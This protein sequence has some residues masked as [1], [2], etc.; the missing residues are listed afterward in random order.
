MN[1][2][3]YILGPLISLLGTISVYLCSFLLAS[4]SKELFGEYSEF[5]FLMNIFVT[6]ASLS[7]D[8]QMVRSQLKGDKDFEPYYFQIGLVINSILSLVYI[9]VLSAIALDDY[10]FSFFII[11]SQFVI[12]FISSIFQIKKLYVYMSI[13]LNLANVLRLIFISFIVFFLDIQDVNY[14]VNGYI[15]IH[16]MV[17]LLS[18]ICFYF[19]FDDVKFNLCRFSINDWSSKRFKGLILLAIAPILHMMIYQS[20]IVLLSHSQPSVVV[21]EYGLALTIITG[22][23]YFPSLIFNKYILPYSLEIGNGGR[24]G[25]KPILSYFIFSAIFTLIV[26]I[27]SDFMYLL[28]FTEYINSVFVLKLLLVGVFFRLLSIPLGSALNAESKIKKKIYTM[29]FVA[30]FNFILNY[31]YIP[32]FGIDAAI[33]TTILSEIILFSFY[34]IIIKS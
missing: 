16:V 22:I 30:T 7:I 3:G 12:V 14:I 5:I 13:I 2:L 24:V 10:F 17:L 34:L 9:L 27:L 29:A 4:E 8:I 26:F 1:S 6:S 25:Y 28:L 33:Y 15:I 19:V 18:V 11:V 23:Y 32:K 31:I 21:A 20:D